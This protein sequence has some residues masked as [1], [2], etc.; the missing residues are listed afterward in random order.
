MADISCLSGRRRVSGLYPLALLD[1][2][3][4]AY[5]FNE[6]SGNFLNGVNPG[7]YDFSSVSS[8]ITRQTTGVSGP[9]F[10][11][12]TGSTAAGGGAPDWGHAQGNQPDSISGCQAFTMEMVVRVPTNV[13]GLVLYFNR[14]DDTEIAGFSVSAGSGFLLAEIQVA[15]V[16]FNSNNLTNGINAAFQHI[17]ATYDGTTFKGYKNGSNIFSVSVGP[18]A[19]GIRT[20]TAGQKMSVAGRTAFGG[21]N[22]AAEVDFL[23]IYT[24]VVL[25]AGQITAHFNASGC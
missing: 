15:G 2:A 16:G 13:G 20:F 19:T 9:D 14:Q 10:K 25:S 24:S 8:N 22:L 7:T 6:A 11:A 23:A 5:K 1:G 12:F 17:V 4:A 18:G 3:I 21:N